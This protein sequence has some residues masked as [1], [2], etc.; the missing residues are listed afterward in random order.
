MLEMRY[1]FDEPSVVDSSKMNSKVGL[2]ATAYDQAIAE[3]LATC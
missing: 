2:H 3:T 1:Q